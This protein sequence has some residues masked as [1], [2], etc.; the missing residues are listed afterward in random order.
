MIIL[1]QLVKKP[2]VHCVIQALG[3]SAECSGG[4]ADNVV[5]ARRVLTARDAAFLASNNEIF[6][7]Q[8]LAREKLETG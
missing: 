2:D 5:A 4:G 1:V 7:Y 6:T 8:L 3:C